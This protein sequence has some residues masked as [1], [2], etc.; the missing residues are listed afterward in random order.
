MH[1]AQKVEGKHLQQV[2]IYYNCVGTIELPELDSIP[3]PE[4]EIQTRKGVAISYSKLNSEA[5]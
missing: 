2:E 4:I 5:S 3:F 1:Q